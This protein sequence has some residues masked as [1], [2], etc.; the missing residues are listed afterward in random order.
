MNVLTTSTT[1]PKEKINFSRKFFVHGDVLMITSRTE[2]GLPFP[3][4]D[5]INSL[6]LGILA[7]AQELYPVEICHYVF[8]SNHFHLIVRVLNPA[9]VPR[10]IGYLKGEMAHVVNRL[11]GRRRKTVFNREYDSPKFLTPE[12]VKKYI[13]Y[14]YLNPA[15]SGLE[16]S[17]NKYPGLSS[18]KAFSGEKRFIQAKKVSRREIKPLPTSSLSITESSRLSAHYMKKAKGRS[19]V[20][21]ITPDAWAESFE[22]FNIDRTNQDILEEI[23]REE[24]RLSEKRKAEN[25]HVIGATSLKRTSMEKEHRPQKF[26]KRM[27]VICSDLRLRIDYLSLYKELCVEAQRIYKK[28]KKGLTKL[29]MPPGMF[30]PAMPVLASAIPPDI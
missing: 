11:L 24:E 1:K 14:L 9:D 22:Y 19:C 30:P 20:L 4:N 7:R 3:P 16:S 12:D 18:W 17:V 25:K 28:W 26:S 2:E 8:L 6:T 13:T 21:E 23:A 10:F 29:T 27:T 15:T 5:L